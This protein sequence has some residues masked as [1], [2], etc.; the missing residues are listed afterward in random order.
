MIKQCCV[1]DA[2]EVVGEMEEDITDV[3]LEAAAIVE[4]NEEEDTEQLIEEPIEGFLFF[5]FFLH[6]QIYTHI[7]FIYI[8]QLY[9]I[10]CLFFFVKNPIVYLFFLPFLLLL[11]GFTLSTTTIVSFIS[12]IIISLLFFFKFDW[13]K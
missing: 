10:H 4:G 5:L 7:Q 6:T 1:N 11:T 8:T 9:N 2:N 12:T 3:N 13:Y